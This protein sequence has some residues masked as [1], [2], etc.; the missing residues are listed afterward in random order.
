MVKGPP[1]RV[2]GFCK[3][4]FLGERPGGL[5]AGLAL[6]VAAAGAVGGDDDDA[7]ALAAV[8]R[9]RHDGVVFDL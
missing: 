8:R 7:P 6:V 4:G 3:G 5:D 9:V 1:S 2:S